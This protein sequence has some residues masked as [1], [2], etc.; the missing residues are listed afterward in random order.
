M[1]LQ[2]ITYLYIVLYN[3]GF[4]II[5]YILGSLTNKRMYKTKY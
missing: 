1:Y 3:N 4:N 5:Y 2:I